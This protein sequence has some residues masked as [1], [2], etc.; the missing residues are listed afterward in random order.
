MH[1]CV[2]YYTPSSSS[3]TQVG[4]WMSGVK[5]AGVWDETVWIVTSDH[6]D[7]QMEHQQFYKMTPYDASARVPMV[8]F[9]PRKVL[10]I[11]C[12]THTLYHTLYTILTHHILYG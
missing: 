7:M 5:E 10:L 11:D 1:L 12:T 4:A 3:S 6:G 2:D 9:D 8:I